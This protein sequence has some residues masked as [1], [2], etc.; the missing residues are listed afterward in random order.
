MDG[1]VYEEIMGPNWCFRSKCLFFINNCLVRCMA[2]KQV[3]GE[4]GVTGCDWCHFVVW[5][6]GVL[7]VEEIHLGDHLWKD[8]NVAKFNNVL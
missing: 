2:P 1:F 4:M 5:T 7:F 8:T 3:Q 6:E